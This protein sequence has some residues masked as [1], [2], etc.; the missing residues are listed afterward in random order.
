MACLVRSVRVNDNMKNGYILMKEYLTEKDCAELAALEGVV[1]KEGINL[2][3]ELDYKKNLS[4][5][6]NTV[7]RNSCCMKEYLYYSDEK[8][9]SYLGI[10]SFGGSIYE[11]NGMTHPDYR[12]RGLFHG[13][14]DHALAECKRFGKDK[15]LL[16]TD[17]KSESGIH[18]MESIGG[19][20]AFSEHRMKLPASEYVSTGSNTDVSQVTLREAATEDAA[21]IHRLDRILYAYEV[22]QEEEEAATE[23]IRSED[24]TL[25]VNTYLIELA[26]ECVGKIR[27]D[28]SDTEGF[29]YGFGILPEYRGKGYG[30]V[31]LR[32][33]LGI[34][35]DKGI[36][37]A[38]LD[39][40]AKNDR[41]LSIYKGCGFRAVSEM[42]YYKNLLS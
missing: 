30:K 7:N 11:L 1:K 18:F 34:I 14:F 31:A 27:I 26:G 21:L 33:A 22:E 38:A 15:L 32:E 40:E 4:D 28:F 19:D 6:K 41:A 23:G 3:L 39:V 36:P 37:G 25:L 9:V 35:F 16:L 20:Y 13:L 12:G 10:C 42:R 8:L 5:Y 24:P 2:K 29:L 17:G